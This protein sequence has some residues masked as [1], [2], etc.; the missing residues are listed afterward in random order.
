M[1]YRKEE[2]MKRKR[3]MKS[4]L[5]KGTALFAAA[6]LSLSMF[7]SS[8]AFADTT[9][10]SAESAEVSTYSKVSAELITSS[11]DLILYQGLDSWTAYDDDDE[12]F[13]YYS[14]WYIDF[15]EGDQIVVTLSD[16]SQLCYTWSYY[17]AW[18]EWDFYDEDD[19]CLS[20]DIESDQYDEHWEVGGTYSF[21]VLIYYE[22]YDSNAT[23]ELEVPVTIAENPY[24]DATAELVTQNPLTLTYAVDSLENTVYDEE[25]N[26]DGTYTYYNIYRILLTEGDQIVITLED[27]DT[28]TYTWDAD[29][30][31]FYDEDGN[32]LSYS[33]YDED[34]QYTDPWEIGGTYTIGIWLDDYGIS[35][36][37]PVTIKALSVSSADTMTAGSSYTANITENG[38][39]VVYAFTPASTGSYT[40]YSTGDYDTVAYVLDAQLNAVAFNDDYDSGDEDDAGLNAHITTDLT[41]GNTYYILFRFY[42]AG[43]TGSFTVYAQSDSTDSSTDTGSGSDTGSS[44]DT[45]STGSTDTGSKITSGTSS[46]APAAQT[47]TVKKTVTKKIKASK[48]KK[49]KVTFKIKASTSGDGKITF[50]KKSGDKALKISKNGKVTVKKGTTKKKTY[51]MKVTVKAAATSAYSEATKTITVKVKVK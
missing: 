2:R 37:V 25:D 9:D 18:D 42:D 20:Y 11:D 6:A 22:G 15:E 47:I 39:Y 44:T 24:A 16:G 4:S 45:G 48:L 3:S 23:V 17:D 28:I 26:A 36:A 13:D 51:K 46:A 49:K 29:D 38:G 8:L 19:N 7:G 27:E 12:E 21:T 31:A 41:A 40:F 1:F 50:T 5:R 14:F 32:G 33:I 35:A 30:L 10:A 43:T 34:D